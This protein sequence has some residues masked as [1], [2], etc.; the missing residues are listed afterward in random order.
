M[1]LTR[2]QRER[3][4]DAVY[5]AL[6]QAILGSLM[7][8]GERLNVDDLARKLGVSLTPVRHAIQQLATEGLVDIKPRSGTFVASLTSS[9][10]SDT[11]DVRCAL[12]CLAAEKAV[13]RAKPAQIRHLRDL[14]KLLRKPV[15]TDEDRQAH[16]QNNLEFHRVLIQGSGNQRLVEVYEAL[17]AH[18]KI[19]RLHS[20][21]GE[22]TTRLAEEQ[23][24][25][26]R[27]VSAFE[28]RNTA[29]L[30]AAVRAH[31]ERAR[32][33]MVAEMQRRKTD[34]DQQD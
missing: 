5:Q 32:D 29:E 16:E 1:E 4:V 13:E 2:I 23:A 17:N 24:E 3:A 19:A 18:I 8:P 22:W 10:I 33:T 6:R 26:E 12:E 31:I 34:A 21:S 14:L 27:I 25:H 11:F 28:A 30:V 9:E 20:S 15:K 7:K